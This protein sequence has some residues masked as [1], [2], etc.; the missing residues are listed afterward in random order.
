MN[1]GDNSDHNNNESGETSGSATREHVA[2]VPKKGPHSSTVWNFFGFDPEDVA[3]KNV[4]CMHYA[5]V[6]AKTGNIVNRLNHLQRHHKI[7]YEQATKDK[8]KNKKSGRQTTQ[9]SIT[10]A[11]PCV[12][13]SV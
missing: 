7:Q 1:E 11:H 12:C 2:L 10:Q 8:P 3:Q 5:P 6:K 4:I 13:V 9:T